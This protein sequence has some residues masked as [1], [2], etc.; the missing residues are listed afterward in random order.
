MGNLFIAKINKKYLYLSMSAR[1]LSREKDLMQC[2][3]IGRFLKVLV[4]KL[5]FKSSPNVWCLLGHFENITFEVKTAVVTFL[6]NLIK[7]WLLF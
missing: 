2:D 4:G 6:G 1:D 7:N 5:S 3:L